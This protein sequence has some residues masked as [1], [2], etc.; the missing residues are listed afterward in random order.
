MRI[1]LAHS[2][3]NERG[4][5]ESYLDLVVR[6]LRDRGHELVRIEPT[7]DAPDASERAAELACAALARSAI[8]LVHVHRVED[9]AWIAALARH[10]P[11]LWSIHDHRPFCPGA[12]R[13]RRDGDACVRV[14]GPGCA[15]EGIQ[16]HCAGLARW[17]LSASRRVAEW[18][19]YRAALVG[20][21]P[22]LVA[23]TF[24]RD[25]AVG[26]GIAARDVVVLPYPVDLPPEAARFAPAAAA[27]LFVGRLVEP[28][29]GLGL[30]TEVLGR[31]PPTTRAVIAGEGPARPWLEARLVAG[32]LRERVEI[33]GWLDRAALA[34]HLHRAAVLVMTSA[35]PEPSGLVG[36]EALAH[37]RPVVA[38]DVGGIG[39]WLADGVVG[40]RV[41]ADDPVAMADRIRALLADH[42]RREAMGRAGRAWVAAHRAPEAHLAVL[43]RLYALVTAR[44]RGTPGA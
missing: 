6:G 31:L 44:S 30:L 21:G 7:A 23:S 42:T 18:S 24:M 11:V 35:W 20:R 1:A 3:G 8:D 17:P 10:F 15:M 19:R 27:V 29:K 14:A 41:P 22:I 2:P 39:E 5:I 16:G 26:Q 9:P 28:D 25:V 40:C 12:N 38:T 4:G 33:V 36:L 34:E 32:G 13:L 37:A 43:E